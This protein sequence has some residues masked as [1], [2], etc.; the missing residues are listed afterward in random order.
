M[1]PRRPRRRARRRSPARP[2]L[3][4]VA[5][6]I[7]VA[8]LIGGLTQVSSQSHSYDTAS[9]RTVAAQGAVLADQSNVTAAQ[10]RR[11]VGDM[12]AQSRQVL[13]SDLDGAVQQTSAQATTAAL[14]A[15]GD[16]T[17]SPGAD[18]ASVFADRAQAM[19]EL[20]D[21]VDGYLGIEQVTPAGSSNAETSVVAGDRSTLSASAATDRIAAAGALLERADRLYASVRAQLAKDVHHP[22]LPASKWVTDPQVW[23]AGTVAANV[24][25]MATSPTLAETHYVVIR[26]VRLDPP[27]LPTAP[28]GS[29]SVSVLSPTTHVGVTVVIANL[30]TAPEPH[31]TVR[32]TM[33]NQTSGATSTQT[34]QTPLALS[35]SAALP[36]V[37]FRVKP[38][39]S[40]ELTVVATA[41]AGQTDLDATVLQQTL[42]VAPAT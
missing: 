26:T 38:G 31:A 28:G 1:S 13:Q 5:A 7:V 42:Q 14:V 40:Y 20:R 35:G 19:R 29:S 12:P 30:G 10:V 17:G 4:F 21:A 3:Y 22:R 2:V 36:E 27:A 15:S 41:P 9:E 39:T 23:Q 11:F 33:A 16:A 18:L 24:D 32:Y 6:A 25:L 34:Q 37:S 8:L